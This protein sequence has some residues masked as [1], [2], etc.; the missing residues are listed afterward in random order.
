MKLTD[1]ITAI[2]AM[3]IVIQFIGQAIGVVLLRN[4]FGSTNLPFKMWLFPLPVVVSIIVWLFL[5]LSTGWFAIWGFL[6]AA[7]GIIVFFL[8]KH[9]RVDENI[10]LKFDSDDKS[11]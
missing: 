7:A 2:L 1:V 11:R 4:K 6:I 5:F 9:N 10:E 3:R 8:T